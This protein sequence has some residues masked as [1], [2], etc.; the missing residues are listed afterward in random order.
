M[1][2]HIIMMSLIVCAMISCVVGCGKK[3]S[4]TSVDWNQRVSSTES[5][6]DVAGDNVAGDGVDEVSNDTDV[7]GVAV[8][9]DLK[10]L[11]RSDEFFNSDFPLQ[12]TM[13]STMLE[14]MQADG[15]IMSYTANGDEYDFD[16]YDGLFYT[17][18]VEDVIL[19]K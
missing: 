19:R 9:Q 1:K 10:S 3:E 11:I 17:V 5:V 12:Q 13:L 14:Q 18:S 15:R 8:I 7:S 2:R 4:N 6:N 16:T